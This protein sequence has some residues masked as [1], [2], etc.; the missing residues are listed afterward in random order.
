[1]MS[2]EDQQMRVIRALERA[3]AAEFGSHFG[4]TMRRSLSR[5]LERDHGDDPA[6]V[7][8]GI[9]IDALRQVDNR[10]LALC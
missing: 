2:I 1:M 4:W 10:V 5:D 3:V 6:A 7:I 8:F 9:T